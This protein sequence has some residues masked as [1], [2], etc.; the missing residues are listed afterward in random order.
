MWLGLGSIARRSWYACR[1]VFYRDLL[2]HFHTSLWHT[3]HANALDSN[4]HKTQYAPMAVMMTYWRRALVPPLAQLV[5]DVITLPKSKHG[6]ARNVGWDMPCENLNRDIK[7]DIKE[8]TQENVAKYCAEYDFTSTVAEGVSEILNAGRSER[9]DMMHKKIDED[10]RKLKEYFRSSIGRSWAEA[11][12]YRPRSKMN[13]NE[14]ATRPW[15]TVLRTAQQDENIT[16]FVK[17]HVRDKAPWHVWREPQ[18]AW[19]PPLYRIVAR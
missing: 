6:G 9:K 15:K 11:T 3:A 10:V 18:P 8:P 5:N 2:P 17:R 1:V 7:D 12:A 13:I 14:R 19:L 16:D 4:A